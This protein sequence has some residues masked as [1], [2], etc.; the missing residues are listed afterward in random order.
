MS[1]VL[2]FKPP[3]RPKPARRGKKIWR[4]PTKEYVR[5]EAEYEIAKDGA[6]NVYTSYLMLHGV[7]PSPQQATAMGLRLGRRVR[8]DD[9]QHYPPKSK[10]EKLHDKK[11][12]ERQKEAARIYDGVLRVQSAIQYVASIQAAPEEIAAYLSQER[13]A[14]GDSDAIE[15]NLDVAI[16]RLQR[17]AAVWRAKHPIKLDV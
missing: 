10:A 15:R 11:V 14:L 6:P 8:A 4:H 12:R 7:Y 17:F 5:A 3:A 2:E 13:P 16:D 1:V 9:G